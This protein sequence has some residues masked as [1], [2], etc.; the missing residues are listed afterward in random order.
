MSV[1]DTEGVDIFPL[2][3]R[4]AEKYGI[5]VVG[6]LAML[7]AESGLKRK[8]AR[9]GT[10]PDISFGYSQLTVQTASGYGIGDG[11]NTAENI[12]AARN[13]LWDRE[14]AIDVGAHHLSGCYGQADGDTLQALIAYNSGQP[15]PEGNWYWQQWAGN[16]ASYK[17]ALKWAQ[18]I[19]K[20]E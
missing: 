16:I 11:Q 6:L 8:A 20:G 1:L 14:T 17:A 5:P 2:V 10:W 15:Q 19:L 9:Y 4:A 7:K 13:T 18:E 12:A 3:A